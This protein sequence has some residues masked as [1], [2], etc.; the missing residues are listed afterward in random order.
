MNVDEFSLRRA[1]A[2]IRGERTVGSDVVE[3]ELT[4]V[5]LQVLG[6]PTIVELLR[7]AREF[8]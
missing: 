2:V 7:A 5:D 3:L 6:M 1:L 4:A 8:V